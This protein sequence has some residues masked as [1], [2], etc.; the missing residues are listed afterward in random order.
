MLEELVSSGLWNSFCE[1][2]ELKPSL[3][4]K[5]QYRTPAYQAKLEAGEA[6]EKFLG[7]A[8]FHT[9]WD[10][11]PKL[12]FRSR[13]MRYGSL[14]R[15]AW[16]WFVENDVKIARA[17]IRDS[18]GGDWM[19]AMTESR[20]FDGLHEEYLNYF[21]GR[22]EQFLDKEKQIIAIQQEALKNTRKM[23]ASHGGVANLLKVLTKTMQQQGASI[24]SIAK[25]QYA[26]CTQA[27]ILLPNEF[28]VDVLVADQIIADD[29]ERR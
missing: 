18:Y 4:L 2:V 23:P 11:L 15:S 5:L 22:R 21:R 9:Q 24:L 19:R 8:S 6:A 12:D 3:T 7:G 25:M 10:L 1:I 16:V 14:E 26:V 28:L 27:G 29:N 20:D 13:P 17:F